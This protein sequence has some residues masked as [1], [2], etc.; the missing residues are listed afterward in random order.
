MPFLW[1]LMVATG[2]HRVYIQ[3]SFLATELHWP[4]VVFEESQHMLLGIIKLW[5]GFVWKTFGIFVL[6]RCQALDEVDGL[7]N[8]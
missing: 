3:E 5:Q 8:H 4:P 2:R 7:E 1:S 6:S